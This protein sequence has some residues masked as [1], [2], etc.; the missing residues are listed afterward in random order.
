VN[1]ESTPIPGLVK[2]I[3]K[4]FYDER[5][6]FLEAFHIKR[7][8][9]LGLV[10]TFVQDNQSFSKKGVLRGLHFQH[11]PYAQGKLVRVLSG[12]VWEIVVDLR[13]KS[14]TFGKHYHC[15][16]DSEKHHQLYVPP[17]MANGFYALEA[18]LFLYK[19]TGYYHPEAESGILW[20]DPE[21]A[22]NWPDK[23]PLVSKK[24]QN[25]PGFEV[26]KK[27]LKFI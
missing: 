14:P 23:D 16:L 12:K 6:Y 8:K 11:P 24:D 10:E 17:G 13:E 20:S 5:G 9:E 7:L 3:P 21:L 18:T 26:L 27:T 22:I 4:I 25:L 2:I 19:C 1:I 15:I